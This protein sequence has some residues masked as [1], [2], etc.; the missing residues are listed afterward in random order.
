M[1]GLMQQMRFLTFEI[2]QTCNM[3]VLH[4]RCPVSDPERYLFGSTK[5]VIDDVFIIKFWLWCRNV[6]GFAGTVLW[7]LYNEPS[8]A[9]TRL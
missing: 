5:N 2:S 6:H 7:H 9:R 1:T 3:A 4:P 8:L